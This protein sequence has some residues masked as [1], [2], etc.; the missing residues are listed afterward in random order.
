MNRR[1]NCTTSL[2]RS[3]NLLDV[4]G[5]LPGRS[6]SRHILQDLTTAGSKAIV[7]SGTPA[8]RRRSAMRFS[9]ACHHRVCS[10]C[11]VLIR[12]VLVPV[13]NAARD[14][15]R[16]K[17]DQFGMSHTSVACVS[18][19]RLAFG[20]GFAASSDLSLFSF[21]PADPSAFSLSLSIPAGVSSP[22]DLKCSSGASSSL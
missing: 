11:S 3:V 8:A 2:K 7:P 19:S 5:R 21:S 10:L 13:R 9:E 15:P 14:R 18:I 4:A 12:T 16:S 17:L 22:K 20:P 6:H 1:S